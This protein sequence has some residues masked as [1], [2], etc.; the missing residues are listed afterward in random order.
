MVAFERDLSGYGFGLRQVASVIAAG[1]VLLATIPVAVTATDGDWGVPGSDFTRTLSFMED[2]EVAAAGAFRVLWLGDPEVLPVAGQEVGDGLAYG[3]SD[4]GPPG[5]D[6]RW[7][8]TGGPTDLVGEALRL[9]ADGRTERLGRLLGPLGIRYLVL[10][11]RSAPARSEMA[12]RMPPEGV[13]ATLAQ[14]L[15]L[16][17]IDVDPAL[18]MYENNAWVPERAALAAASGADVH[19]AVA[20]SEPF[21][22]TVGLDLSASSP[23]LDGSGSAVR[24]QGDVPAGTVYLAEAASPRWR[25]ES[26]GE[27]AERATAFGW[28]NAFT[29]AEPG[30][31]T[32]RYRTS[33]LRWLAVTGQALLWLMAAGAVVRLCRSATTS[34]T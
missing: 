18:T 27:V 26:G 19:G 11:E 28:A 16:R 17:G 1:G 25:L 21:E 33:P 24:F 31:A 34:R 30:E 3:M 9:A 10:A 15:D 32:L 7:A 29:V 4:N 14:Q 5:I 20:A 22:A 23:V 13:A 6:D 8:N 2:D 12:V